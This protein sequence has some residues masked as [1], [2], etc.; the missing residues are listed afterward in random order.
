[1]R[2]S[3]DTSWIGR[4]S[5]CFRRISRVARFV[6]PRPDL[7]DSW[8]QPISP[9]RIITHLAKLVLAPMA[10]K[11][12]RRAYS[13]SEATIGLSPS[14]AGPRVPRTGTVKTT[15]RYAPPGIPQSFVSVSSESRCFG[16]PKQLIRDI[17]SKALT[18]QKTKSRCVGAPVSSHLPQLRQE[19]SSSFRRRQI[20]RIAARPNHK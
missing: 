14:P 10:P 17:L 19:I 9:S 18:A 2:I 1:M 16:F 20:G 7:R 13:G 15:K 3:A 8:L 11:T 6:R 12:S 5:R 4:C